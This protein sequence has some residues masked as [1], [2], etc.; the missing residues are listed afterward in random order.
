MAIQQANGQV[1]PCSSLP[2]PIFGAVR[3]P[4][5]YWDGWIRGTVGL[6]QRTVGL[7]LL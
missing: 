1:I 5:S 2:A 3:L 4:N 7:V 6:A